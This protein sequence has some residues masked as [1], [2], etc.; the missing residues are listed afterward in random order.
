M[1]VKTIVRMV[2]DIA[3]TINNHYRK[4]NIVSF[5]PT[6]CHVIYRATMELISLR[7]AMDEEEW[8][9]A[10]ETLREATWNYG[11]RWQAAGKSW[12]TL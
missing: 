12:C 3:H 5:P 6:Y 11:R 8:S 2:V 9:G 1:A 7:N 10:L 4:I